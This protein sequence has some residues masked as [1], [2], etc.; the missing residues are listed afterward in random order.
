MVRNEVVGGRV[1][2]MMVWS[3][4]VGGRVRC[5]CVM[6]RSEVGGERVIVRREVGEGWGEEKEH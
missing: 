3:E 5:E 6:V 4:V 1:R 2:C